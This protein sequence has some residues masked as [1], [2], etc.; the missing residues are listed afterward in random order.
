ME[1]RLKSPSQQ[2]H[3]EVYRE[4]LTFLTLIK[5]MSELERSR[6]QPFDG[7][8]PAFLFETLSVSSPQREEL[9]SLLEQ[10]V[11]AGVATWFQAAMGRSSE[12][13]P[14]C[15]LSA[16]KR[17]IGRLVSTNEP[18]ILF[19]IPDDDFI[20]F[21]FAQQA[22]QL[23]SQGVRVPNVVLID[24]R[25]DENGTSFLATES[26]GTLFVERGY[27]VSPDG[28][29][30]YATFQNPLAVA[31]FGCPSSRY[32]SLQVFL[33]HCGI[34]SFSRWSEKG[35]DRAIELLSRA[36]KGIR[37]PSALVVNRNSTSSQDLRVFL[38]S[39]AGSELRITRAQS[40][41]DFGQDLK[42][43]SGLNN[44]N[45]HSAL[46]EM[47][48]DSLVEEA[49][50]YR[51]PPLQRALNLQ[52]QDAPYTEWCIRA[53]TTGNECV[54][55]HLMLYSTSSS[56]RVVSFDQVVGQLSVE[57]ASWLEQARQAV[58]Q[59]AALLGS[60]ITS[61]ALSSSWVIDRKGPVLTHL[62]AGHATFLSER[63]S[64][65]LRDDEVVAQLLQKLVL[66]APVELESRDRLV[67]LKE[68]QNPFQLG[69]VVTPISN[70]ATGDEPTLIED[71]EGVL[72]QISLEDVR[73]L[74]DLV[75]T[76][77]SPE[78]R[79]SAYYSE[80]VGL[81]ESCPK[82]IAIPILYGIGSTLYEGSE[83]ASS[84]IQRYALISALALADGAV[85]LA[86]AKSALEIAAEHRDAL[87]RKRV[88]EELESK[89]LQGRLI[90]P[91]SGT[92]MDC[93]SSLDVDQLPSLPD[94]SDL[95]K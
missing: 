14:A 35:L 57:D 37:T 71:E 19:V 54:S 13:Q 32:L 81:A 15:F 49:V 8:N 66:P 25:F 77:A 33:D 44:P 51:I 55:E 4:S 5:I 68:V 48:S 53:L 76:M 64:T 84:E 20:P 42:I 6:N 56:A 90:V 40:P 38:E 45:T 69:E 34:E 27:L 43:D 2:Q 78:R 31:A 50:V 16:S 47:F 82:E 92:I 61:L 60:S 1:S 67:L 29:V 74:L 80:V 93:I 17:E 3:Q 11:Q 41:F 85:S 9:L 12:D 36:P 79:A 59:K 18:T 21:R 94:V 87:L 91:P 62:S 95:D 7:L 28:E 58:R 23:R 72:L 24:G 73:S 63:S 86:L 46:Q 52:S 22:Q 65:G 75:A 88:V 70:T 30:C 83:V 89:V 10:Q 39:F 26:G